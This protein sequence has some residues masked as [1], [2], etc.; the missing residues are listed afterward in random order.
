M[1]TQNLPAPQRGFDQGALATM[2]AGQTAQV[3]FAPGTFVE[4]VE[5]ARMMA[6]SGPAVPKHLRNNPGMAMS[7]CM[8]AYQAGMNPYLL[9]GDTFVVNDVLSYGAKAMVAILYASGM[10]V[11]RLHYELSGSW[12]NR[13]CVVRGTLAG[14]SAPRLLE[15]TANTITTRNS[16]LWKTQPDIQ[17]QY[18]AGRAWARLYAPEALL[19]AL[20]VDEAEVQV[21]VGRGGAP[22]GS[23][24][25]SLMA[26]ISACPPE[27]DFD[28]VTGEVNAALT[29]IP[30]PDNTNG[31]KDYPAW[32]RLLADALGAALT[33]EH[34]NAI[35][36]ANSAEMAEAERAA[37]KAYAGLM[38][39]IDEMARR[40]FD[41]DQEAR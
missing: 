31:L 35:Q 12:P 32:L 7:V 23:A 9:A 29:P 38:V 25:A 40:L 39:A 41:P 4:M 36:E 1:S 30:V 37:P 18:Y 10:V 28:P 2:R 26:E 20:S 22:I 13:V 27:K 33:I 21:Q 19:G 34:F 16:P 3:A 8:V 11:G 5:V 24:A 17:L 6:A 15:V 14:E